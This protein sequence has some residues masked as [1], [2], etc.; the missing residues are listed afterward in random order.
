MFLLRRLPALVALLMLGALTLRLGSPLLVTVP[1]NLLLLVLLVIPRALLQTVLSA[2]LWVGALAWLGM[3][4]VRVNERLT[5]GQ[6]WIR[7][8]TIFGAV[9]LFTAWSAWLLRE[10]KA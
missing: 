2:M 9:T 8:V 10:K 1:L 4:W 3:A 5:L 7:L 6:P